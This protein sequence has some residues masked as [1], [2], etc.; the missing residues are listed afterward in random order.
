VF[1]DAPLAVVEAR[2][3]K[4]LYRKARAGEIAN[5]TGISSPYEAPAHP[6]IHLH[7]DLKDAETLAEEI[8]E[9][10]WSGG[11]LGRR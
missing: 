4:R 1:V 10:L 5:F 7:T 6:E 2:D 9:T 11:Y 8:V 3:P